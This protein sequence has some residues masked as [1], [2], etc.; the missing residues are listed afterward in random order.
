MADKAD[1]QTVDT[2]SVTNLKTVGESFAFALAQ[3]SQNNM[4]H[5]KSMDMLRE[6]Y[7]GTAL[8]R[9]GTTDVAESAGLQGIIKQNADSGIASLLAQL[10]AGQIGSKVGQSTAGDPSLEIAKISGVLTSINQNNSAMLSAIT[11]LSNQIAAN[12]G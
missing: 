1:P 6:G 11:A 7:M 3:I 2:L 9:F 10:V 12:K 8:E 4:T 5:T